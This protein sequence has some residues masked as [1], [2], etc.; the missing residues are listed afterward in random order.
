MKKIIII[1][2]ILIPALFY[3][4]IFGSYYGYT[5]IKEKNYDEGKRDG[6]E[7]GRFEQL[8]EDFST[9]DKDKQDN[10]L[11]S[12]SMLE[13]S[14]GKYRKILDTNNQYSLGLYHFQ[15]K[16]VKDMY[17]RY[18]KINITTEEA[19]KIAEDDTKAT[20]LA[21]Y[22][23]FTKHELFHWHNSMNKLCNVGLISYR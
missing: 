7:I 1:G 8:N 17:R 3:A 6:Y 2:G 14:G 16:T 9:Q 22:A 15:A 19:I 23:I 18:Y 11:Y 4:L 5:H 20:E 12:L 21:R 13:S 10:I